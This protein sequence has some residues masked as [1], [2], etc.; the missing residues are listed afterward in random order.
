MANAREWLEGARV[1]TLTVSASPVVAGTAVA[2]FASS[3]GPSPLL[4]VAALCLVVGLG[5]QV[6]CNYANDYSDGIRGTDAHRVGPARLV[7][8]GAA[9]PA[10]VKRAALI[11]FAVACLAGIALVVRPGAYPSPVAPVAIVAVGAACVVAA[12]FYT[13]GRRPYG[14]A[15]LGEVFVF[16]FFGLVA[17]IGTAFVLAPSGLAWVP[18][19]VTGVVMGLF[20]VAVLVANNLRDIPT[21][22]MSG[23]LTL[24]VRLGDR[25]TRFFYVGLLALA[26]AGI[27]VLAGVTT[28]FALAGLAGLVLLWPSCRRVMS[29]ASGV[30]LVHVLK[31]TGIAE[32]VTAV[33]LGAGLAIGLAHG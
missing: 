26:G 12:W 5:M 25:R 30:A 14:Y 24:P 22:A 2:W 1:R 17:T 19:V 28:W 21:D 20:A 31:L 7:G 33:L 3:P 13:G 32:L 15:G 11:S 18:A 4:L 9:R 8:S 6:G 16:V 23:K 27:V 29:G 10:A